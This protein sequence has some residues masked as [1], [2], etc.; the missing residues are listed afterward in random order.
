[1]SFNKF[2]VKDAVEAASVYSKMVNDLTA[3]GWDQAKFQKILEWYQNQT[4]LFSN[5]QISIPSS[6][7][8]VSYFAPG[9]YPISNIFLP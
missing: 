2:L 6:P 1:M 5:A 4:Q 7:K 3:N 9:I 8:P